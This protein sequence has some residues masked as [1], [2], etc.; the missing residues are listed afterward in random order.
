[1]T[2]NQEDTMY[3]IHTQLEKLKLNSKFDKQLKKMATQEKHKWKD[4]CEKW[5]YAFNKVKNKAK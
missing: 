1:M 3:E 2:K 4:L 5:E